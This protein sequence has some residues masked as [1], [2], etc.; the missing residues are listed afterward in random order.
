MSLLQWQ[1]ETDPRKKQK[2][3]LAIDE[4]KNVSMYFKRNKK[5][6][7]HICPLINMF[8]IVG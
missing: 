5:M 7:F 2:L 8:Y 6:N 3:E 1:Q 4:M